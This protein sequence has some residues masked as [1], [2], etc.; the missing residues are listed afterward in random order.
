LRIEIR[1]LLFIAGQ[2]QHRSQNLNK[3]TDRPSVQTIMEIFSLVEV[4]IISG[5]RYF[6]ETTPLQLQAINRVEWAGYDPDEVY[7]GPLACNL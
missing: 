7:L 4:L 1:I 3:K 6:P 5:E 2:H